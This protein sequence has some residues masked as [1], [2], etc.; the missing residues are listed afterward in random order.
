MRWCLRVKLAQN[1][2]EFGRLLLPTRDRPIVEQF[3]K[4]DCWGAK[5]TDAAGNTLI[6]QNV[7]GRLLIELREKLKGDADGALETVPPPLGIPDLLL[8]GWPIGPV[9]ARGISY[10]QRPQSALF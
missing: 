8:L 10:E 7:L 1:Y 4:D 3:R 2:E 6:G 9:M 5:L